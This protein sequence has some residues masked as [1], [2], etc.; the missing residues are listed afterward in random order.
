MS[1]GEIDDFIAKN[2][3]KKTQKITR[4]HFSEL[5]MRNLD[6]KLFNWFAEI[7]D[8]YAGTMNA[9]TPMTAR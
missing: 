1:T 6:N 4:K 7:K 2:K 5:F 9:Q 3:I 8:D